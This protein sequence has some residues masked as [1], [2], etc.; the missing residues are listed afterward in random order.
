ESGARGASMAGAFTAAADDVEAIWWNPAGL[1]F[2]RNIEVNSIYTTLF[3]LDDLRY[4]NF[5][6]AVPTLTA[7]TWGLG[8]SSFGPAEYRETDLRLSFAACLTRGMYLGTNLKSNT[9]KI[10]NEGGTANAL[11][12]DMGVVANVNEK[13]KMGMSALNVNSPT[14]GDTSENLARRFLFG[15]QSKLLREVQVNFDLHKPLKQEMEVRTGI[16]FFLNDYVTLR[17][18]V[19]TI[20]S[21]FTMGFGVNKSIF[22]VEY[23]FMTHTVLFSQHMFGLKMRF[24]GPPPE[25]RTDYYDASAEE[26]YIRIV[27]INTAGISR[28]SMLPG[29][30]KLDAKKIIEYREKSGSFASIKEIMNIY[31]FPMAK[32]DKFKD[33]ITVGEEEGKKVRVRVKK[34]APVKKQQMEEEFEIQP[35]P[36]YEEPEEI[37]PEEEVQPEQEEETRPEPEPEAET[38]K[39]NINKANI[40]ELNKIQGISF[41]LAKKIVRYRKYHGKFKKMEDLLK[42][43]GINKKLLEKIKE[44]GSVE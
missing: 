19:Q 43:P 24:G 42:V 26:K 20:P 35:E 29:M 9:I 28:L 7:G 30:G 36:G 13:L 25:S 10:G 38:E 39:I 22:S 15:L 14:L 37:E 23:A 31:G 3:G 2:C 12:M 1:R 17:A 5:S 18:G 8:Y 33:Y 32:Y 41:S 34:K 16:E 21:R 6:F 27:N 40:K 4:A 44:G 11:G